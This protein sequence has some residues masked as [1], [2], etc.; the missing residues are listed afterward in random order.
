MIE[1]IK[2]AFLDLL[3]EVDWMDAETRSEARQKVTS[4]HILFLKL[5]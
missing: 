3:D 2:T 5:L 4:L 1:N